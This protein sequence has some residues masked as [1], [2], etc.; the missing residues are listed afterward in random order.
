[1]SSTD[2]SRSKAAMNGQVGV[3][4]SRSVRLVEHC[5]TVVSFPEPHRTPV[6]PA[7]WA[8][9]TA[10]Q[11]DAVLRACDMA[12]DCVAFRVGSVWDPAVDYRVYALTNQD[13]A[14]VCVACVCSIGEG[15]PRAPQNHRLLGLGQ[16]TRQA[17]RIALDFFNWDLEAQGEGWR[18]GVQ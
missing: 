6:L 15:R 18:L 12:P 11:V 9:L 14:G 1:M 16:D 5:G 2:W 13:W 8:P 3:R 4:R 7:G 10:E 17:V